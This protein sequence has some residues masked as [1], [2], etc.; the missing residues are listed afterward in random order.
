MSVLATSIIPTDKSA[1]GH[2]PP[3]F[4]VEKSVPE[5][6]Y[7][8]TGEWVVLDKANKGQKKLLFK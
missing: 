5:G 1:S 3:C 4:P 6:H 2:I 8:L 7:T